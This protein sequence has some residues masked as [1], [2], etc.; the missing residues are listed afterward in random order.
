MRTRMLDAQIRPRPARRHPPRG[1][2]PARLAGARDRARF[3]SRSRRR[4]ASRATLDVDAQR[5]A[6]PAAAARRRRARRRSRCA[7]DGVAIND[8]R[9][10]GDDAGD[11]RCPATRIVVETEVEIAPR[12]QHAADGALRLGRHSLHA[13]RGRG[14]PPHHLLPRPA[15][16]AQPLYG[17]DDRRQGALPGA[18]RQ[19]R[20][21]RAGRSATTA[22][23]G[24]NGTI[25]SP[26]RAICSR[27][28][29]AIS[30]ANRDSFTTMSGREVELG[31][32][33]RAADLPKTDHALARAQ[34]RDG[35]GRDGLWP[36][37]RSRRVQHR[38]GRRFQLRRDGEQGAQHLQHAATSWPIPTPRPTAITTRS[39]RVVAH[40]Y[41]HNWSG[42]RVTC[43]DWFQLS[44]EGRLH[45]LSRP[46][47]LGRPGLG[48]G[49]A[50]RGCAR[51]CARRNSPRMPA[52]SRTRSGPNAYIEISQLLHR[53]D[54][55]QGRRGHPDDARRSWGR[56]GFRAGTDLYFDRY[57]GDGGDLRGFRRVRWRTAAAS[58]STQFRRWYSAG[59][60][61][62]RVGQRSTMTRRAAARR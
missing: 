42:N 50:D 33:V 23:I 19:R 54:L 35:V 30:S 20:S 25:P 58:T 52:R 47:L 2:S 39:P 59:R 55:Q 46:G 31:I 13:V 41:F 38:R 12:P 11:R 56:S 49:Q 15:R 44:P 8:W 5:R 45:R 53:D 21:D 26:S 3:R 9:M 61:A 32:W 37:I 34:D 6:R 60:H 24:P 27:W 57:D 10:D 16:R 14:L 18:A 51:R 36:R 48:R 43:R 4:R 22:G 62:A 7:V 28:S 40:E 1:L 17:A 29:R